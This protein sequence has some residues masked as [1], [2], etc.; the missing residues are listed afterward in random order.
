MG[1]Q[2]EFRTHAAL[3]LNLAQQA[4]SAATKGRLLALAE[5]WLNLANRRSK[6][7]RQEP[8]TIHADDEQHRE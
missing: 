1:K 2:D 3:S 6:N 7:P 4:S 8:L 5:A